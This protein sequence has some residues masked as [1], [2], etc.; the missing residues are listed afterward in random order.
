MNPGLHSFTPL[1]S[2]GVRRLFTARAASAQARPARED[3]ALTRS[4]SPAQDRFVGLVL[5]LALL[6]AASALIALMVVLFQLSR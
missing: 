3:D 5:G 2:S 1:P 4:V 6:G